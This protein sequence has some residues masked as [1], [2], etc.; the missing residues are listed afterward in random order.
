MS[1][2]HEYELKKVGCRQDK[3]GGWLVTLRIHIE[4]RDSDLVLAP[5][6]TV[7]AGPLREEGYDGGAH[8]DD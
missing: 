2:A 7:F 8:G 6:G 1:D 3:D 4:D 5:A